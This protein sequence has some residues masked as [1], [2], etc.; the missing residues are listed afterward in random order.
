MTSPF[1]PES[2]TLTADDFSRIS[3]LVHR[4]AGIDLRRGK[5]RLVTTR[6]SRRLREL[7]LDSFDEYCE[8]VQGDNTGRELTALID[9][10]TTNYTSFFR[11]PAHFEFLRDTILPALSTRG[12]I[13]LWSSACATGEEPWSM[14][15]TMLEA[16]GSEALTRVRILA[17]DISTRALATAARA[18]YPSSAFDAG[19]ASR[20]H[21]WLM[22]GEN[23]SAGWYRLKPE[24]CRMVEFRR[25][26][27]IEPV[28]SAGRFPLI[29]C[30]N[31]M[32]YFDGPTREKVVNGLVECLEPGG[33]LFV[34]HAEG[35]NGIRHPLR[36]VC[37]AIYQKPG[38][39][40]DGDRREGDRRVIPRFEAD[41]RLGDRR[42]GNR[43]EGDRR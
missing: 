27:L 18:T 15:L 26:N 17:T 20:L 12:P 24:V 25:L 33:Y 5:E 32:I 35:L 38:N 41:R 13:R 30:R 14:A 11:E 1:G 9:A 36:Y 2:A 37:P 3:Q 29:F 28:S 16:L 22:R 31:V 8:L 19:T 23:A 39:L 6:L 21:T 7:S 34:G 40:Q 4:H 42:E 43:R 10:I